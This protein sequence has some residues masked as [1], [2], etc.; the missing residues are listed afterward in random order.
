MHMCEASTTTATPCGL[1]MASRAVAICLVSRSWTC[2]RLPYMLA[3]R[4]SLDSL[5][6]T[7]TECDKRSAA[8]HTTHTHTHNTHTPKVEGPCAAVRAPPDTESVASGLPG[9]E[10]LFRGGGKGASLCGC[11]KLLE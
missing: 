9:G 8:T 1:R 3:I 2:R 6:R 7:H 4:A 5:Q 10:S 11:N